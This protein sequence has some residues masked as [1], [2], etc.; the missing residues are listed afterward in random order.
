[1]PLRVYNNT[2][3]VQ[4]TMIKRFK[5]PQEY[6]LVF[7]RFMRNKQITVEEQVELFQFILDTDQQTICDRIEKTSEY[8]L[9]EGFLY[10]VHTGD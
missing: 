8:M 3:R 10:Y 9:A 2:V 6:K 1:M 7:H 4:K 5:G